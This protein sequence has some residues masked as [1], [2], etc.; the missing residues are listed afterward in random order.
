MLTVKRTIRHVIKVN[1]LLLDG[2]L[3]LLLAKA[4]LISVCCC[5]EQH[6]II[7]LL[8]GKVSH[9]TMRSEP[10]CYPSSRADCCRMD[11]LLQSGRRCLSAAH[12]KKYIYIVLRSG[13][14]TG[15]ASFF[16]CRETEK[17]VWCYVNT[18]TNR[19]DCT[20]QLAN[21]KKHPVVFAV[22]SNSIQIIFYIKHLFNLLLF[23][24]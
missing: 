14:S 16:R 15:E 22:W 1:V 9:G 7:L 6:Y 2:C 8:P 24:P 3:S 18:Q 13:S 11:P 19:H 21:V 23:S 10:P 20:Q 5:C 12:K 17:S 4:H